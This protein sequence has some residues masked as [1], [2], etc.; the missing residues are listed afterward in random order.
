MMNDRLAR[1]PKEPGCYEQEEATNESG[2]DLMK[3]VN[4]FGQVSRKL[5]EE[6]RRKEVKVK[7]MEGTLLILYPRPRQDPRAVFLH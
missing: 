2:D 7:R 3:R 5:R 6:R 1:Y 4:P